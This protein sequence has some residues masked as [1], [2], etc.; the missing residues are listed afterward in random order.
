MSL[1][2]NK[3]ITSK[4]FNIPLTFDQLTVV[5]YILDEVQF[6]F[7]WDADDKR[8]TNDGSEPYLVLD[9][10]QLK[11]LQSAAKKFTYK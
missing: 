4:K 10:Y 2:T 5:R 8:Y 9:R 3:K 6:G 7:G 1:A 11:S